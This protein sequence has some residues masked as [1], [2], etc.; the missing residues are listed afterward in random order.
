M[1]LKTFLRLEVDSQVF[2]FARLLLY[3]IKR[4]LMSDFDKTLPPEG[5]FRKPGDPTL[6]WQA[7][8]RKL[9]ANCL[10]RIDPNSF[11]LTF[12]IRKPTSIIWSHNTETHFGR[13]TLTVDD[14]NS[15]IHPYWA[16][17][18]RAY[19]ASGYKI[20]RLM[21][22]DG[23]VAVRTYK[24]SVPLR[25]K[26]GSYFWYTQVVFPGGLDDFRNLVRH[27]NE[28]HR[29]CEFDRLAPSPPQMS[30]DG[31]VDAYHSNL[32]K[33]LN[34]IAMDEVLSNLLTVASFRNLQAYRRN[35]KLS[36][37]RWI[38]PTSSEMKEVLDLTQSALN[39]ANTRILKS[40]SLMFPSITLTSVANFAVILNE[41]YGS[42]AV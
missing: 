36:K 15:L 10:E 12:D 42:P 25:Q 2:R 18:S 13:K 16:A 9:Q 22:N 37:N 35:C 8:L 38:A 34:G 41:M 29:C 30:T 23:K 39:R 11:Y 26:D 17:L 14:Y 1:I 28:Y 32:L 20:A 33:P 19:A 6:R 5:D 7:E 4:L 27:H 31:E 24:A 3:L 21:A 40:A